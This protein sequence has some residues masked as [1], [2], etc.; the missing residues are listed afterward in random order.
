MAERRL[1]RKKM[2]DNKIKLLNFFLSSGRDFLQEVLEVYTSPGLLYGELE[3]STYFFNLSHAE[4]ESLFSLKKENKFSDLELDQVFEFLRRFTRIRQPACAWCG[5]C[6]LA[7]FDS[8]HV[9]ENIEKL[10]SI[11]NV[12]NKTNSIPSEQYKEYVRTLTNIGHNVSTLL[13]CGKSFRE[14][15]NQELGKIGKVQ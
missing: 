8:E 7:D 1:N 6:S 12:V 13:A 10:M 4:Q 15:V 9:G 14:S 5:Q 3:R 2:V 11:W